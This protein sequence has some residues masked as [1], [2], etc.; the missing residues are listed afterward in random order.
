MSDNIYDIINRLNKAAPADVPTKPSKVLQESSGPATVA[1]RL[2]EK[3]MGWKKTVDAIKK[4]GSADNPEAVAAAIGRKKYGKAKFQKA[5]AAGKKLG[6]ASKPDF[7]DLDK[8][9]NKKE[10]MKTAAKQKKVKESKCMECGMYES[11]CGCDEG[12]AFGKAVRDAKKD[13]IQ[14]GE[15]VVVGGKSYPVKETKAPW[16]GT[17]EYKKKHGE[18]GM[19]SG[20][21]K[22]S[23]SG[24]EIEKTAKGIKHTARDRS[25][26]EE[27]HRPIDGE[28]RGRGRP[29]KY[30]ADKP[31]QERVTAKSRKKDRTAWT[32]KK[33]SES[34]VLPIQVAESVLSGKL[35]PYKVLS[36][37]DLVD[38]SIPL[39][40]EGIYESIARENNFDYDKDFN[41][42]MSLIKQRIISEGRQALQE[43]HDEVDVDEVDIEDKGEYDQEGDMAKDQLHSIEQAAEELSSLLDDEDNLPEWVQS[44]ITKA[45][46]YLQAS[47]QYMDQEEHDLDESGLQAYLGK[48]KYG[49][50]GM[51]ALQQA[52]REG[53]SK[54]KM[55]KIRAQHDQFDEASALSEKSVSQQQQKF[56][57]MAHAMQKGQKIKGAS[58]ELKKVARTMKKGDVTDFAKTKHAG[59][60]KRV[61]AG[62]PVAEDD[63]EEGLGDVIKRGVKS[64]T[65]T[66]RV[67]DA[68]TKH[69]DKAD[70][71]GGDKER[72]RAVKALY[73]GGPDT[74]EKAFDKFHKE[75]HGF[76]P[77][78][79]AD[80]DETGIGEELRGGQ[81][82]IDMNKNGKLDAQD[83]KMLRQGKKKTQETTVSGSVAPGAAPMGKMRRRT[84]E[85]GG[86]G[87][88]AA[89]KPYR[90]PK[91]GKMV[92]P[93]KGA[94]QP[95]ADSKFP[96]GDKRNA[97]PVKKAE[98]PQGDQAVAET[99][100][101]PTDAASKKTK[102]SG[103]MQFGKGIYDSMNRDLEA[104]IAENLTINTSMNTNGENNVTV[105][106]TDEDAA[107]LMMLLKMAGVGGHDGCPHC[108]ESPCGC[109]QP[110]DEVSQN[111]PDYPENMGQTDDPIFMLK[112]LSGGL[113]K[114]KATGQ[115]T[116]PVIA[117]QQDR[118]NMEESAKLES[119]LW[120]LYKKIK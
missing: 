62:K 22:K 91:S 33:V 69:M 1:S 58:P 68:Y 67:K 41:K 13:G 59:L 20:D 107:K 114:P 86:A 51:R 54:E 103:G 96:P 21:K 72:R 5:A 14:K 111:E 44:K 26:D 23:S 89:E 47:N 95:P 117:G 16:P 88:I 27:D 119:S 83:F 39:Y 118:M 92:T 7:L 11:K 60:P 110:L 85:D 12:N 113:N 30:T 104:M 56:M 42:I 79:N 87:G 84:E 55:A 32:K 98:A 29:K 10:P 38:P 106:A 108:G 64:M 93:P 77:K 31:R 43:F 78:R 17:D 2:D 50:E 66:N 8:D 24:G 74:A 15:K 9:G 4:G 48:K 36:G 76:K 120:T 97:V 65:G 71:G 102:S 61:K 52:G 35:D 63:M 109:D 45:L 94:T 6:E 70:A 49:K 3:Y 99:D 40:I 25:D 75:K 100:K 105:T 19:K 81:K 80:Y 53:A 115:T 34:I 82:K 46:D 90:D 37:L 18:P 116:V 73:V 28:K 101:N 112:T 57:G